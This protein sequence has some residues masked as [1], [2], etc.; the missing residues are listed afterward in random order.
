[1]NEEIWN[2][3]AF[4][5]SKF[6]ASKF[7]TNPAIYTISHSINHTF[8]T[9]DFTAIIISQKYK[10][11]F[12]LSHILTVYLRASL[13]FTFTFSYFDCLSERPTS[14]FF[15]V[16]MTT[17]LSPLQCFQILSDKSYYF[18][19]FYNVRWRRSI[20]IFVSRCLKVHFLNL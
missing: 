15:L 1:M 12:N 8:P 3:S 9:L 20:I 10:A 2:F 17:P 19:S 5:A 14:L 16:Q 11:G 6:V 4:V 13:F 18:S 7:Q